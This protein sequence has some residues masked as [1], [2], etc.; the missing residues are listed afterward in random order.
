VTAKQQQQLVQH[1]STAHLAYHV[2][3]SGCKTS[4]INQSSTSLSTI[5]LFHD[6]DSHI[7]YFFCLM[8]I[9]AESGLCFIYALS[10][11]GL[12]TLVPTTQGKQG[13]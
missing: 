7:S 9:L 3:K 1:A 8:V 10:L 11:V 5:N 2:H 4:I 6:D 13:R 12:G